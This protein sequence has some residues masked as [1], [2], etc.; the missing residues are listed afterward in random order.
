MQIIGSGITIGENALMLPFTVTGAIGHEP[1]EIIG[2]WLAGQHEAHLDV[3]R[4]RKKPL[5]FQEMQTANDF[6]HNSVK[7]TSF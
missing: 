2:G 7:S 5:R 4:K 3:V 1:L 6:R